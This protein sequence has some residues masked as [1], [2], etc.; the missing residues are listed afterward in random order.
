M[1]SSVFEV[2]ISPS[3]NS[4]GWSWGQMQICYWKDTSMSQG[5]SRMSQC[6]VWSNRQLQLQAYKLVIYCAI[7]DGHLVRQTSYWYSSLV[8]SVTI[9]NT[10]IDIP[11]EPRAHTKQAGGKQ[12]RCHAR[13]NYFM[14]V[15]TKYTIF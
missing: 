4:W 11:S 13:N 7:V 1:L 12:H 3:R 10:Y 5:I 14:L 6:S 9:L 15:R 8:Y 2:W